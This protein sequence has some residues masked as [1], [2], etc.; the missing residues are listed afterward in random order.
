[1]EEKKELSLKELMAIQNSFDQ[2]HSSTFDWAVPITMDNL[3]LLSFRVVCMVSELGEASN[4][5]KKII[6][7][8]F[9][10]EEVRDELEEEIT[11]LFIYLMITCNQLGIDL[12]AEYLKKLEKNKIRFK[13]YEI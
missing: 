3:E 13:R 10:L 9:T 2:N 8:D 12:E 7:G 4:I 5:V 11:D 6:R 1:M